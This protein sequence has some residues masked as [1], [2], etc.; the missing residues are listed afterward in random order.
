MNDVVV[1]AY[2]DVY[3]MVKEKEGRAVVISSYLI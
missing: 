2:I 1:T 3:F